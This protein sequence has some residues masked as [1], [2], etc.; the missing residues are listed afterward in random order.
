MELLGAY[1]SLTTVH[2]LVRLGSEQD[3]GPRL[4]SD[5]D[6]RSSA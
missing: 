5:M 3:D 2:S 6:L 4:F 1:E